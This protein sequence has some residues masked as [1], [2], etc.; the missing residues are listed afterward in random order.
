MPKNLKK[1]KSNNLLIK[2][3]KLDKGRS[4][5]SG[6]VNGKRP[7]FRQGVNHQ[8]TMFLACGR[9]APSIAATRTKVA[10]EPG[11]GSRL[12]PTL[13][14]LGDRASFSILTT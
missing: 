5:F 3:M 10:G 13:T 2:G 9:L 7:F 4:N 6:T 11:R 12:G 8:M 14:L 1:Q